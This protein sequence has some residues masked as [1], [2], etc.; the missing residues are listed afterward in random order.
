[1]SNLIIS[2]RRL[3][4]AGSI[5][6][7]KIRKMLKSGEITDKEYEFIVAPEDKGGKR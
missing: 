7:L 1:M 6:I 4:L 3:Y 2:L 5:D